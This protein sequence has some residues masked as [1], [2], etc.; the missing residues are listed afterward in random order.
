MERKRKSQQIE[1]CSLPVCCLEAGL[2]VSVSRTCF[3]SLN[4]SPNVQGMGKR[5]RNRQSASQVQPYETQE[6]KLCK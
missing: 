4:R 6:T 1:E 3:T 5:S 2:D